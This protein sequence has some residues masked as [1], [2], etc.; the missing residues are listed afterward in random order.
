MIRRPPRSTRTDTLFPYTTLFRSDGEED[1][2]GEGEEELEPL[3]QDDPVDPDR[4]RDGGRPHQARILVEGS[5]EVGDGGVEPDPRQQSRDQEDDVR[6]LADRTLEDL[7][8]DEPVD[9]AHNQ[10]VE[11]RPQVAEAAGGMAHP[12]T[13]KIGQTPGREK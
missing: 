4:A 11:H 12:Q 5:G 6:Y 1:E 13:A 10:R 3:A 7:R 8:E 2:H 9:E